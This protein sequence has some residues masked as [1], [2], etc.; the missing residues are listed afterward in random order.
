M[1]QSRYGRGQA[2]E[3]LDLEV[4]ARVGPS[5]NTRVGRLFIL[6]SSSSASVA[7]ASLAV[8]GVKPNASKS[9]PHVSL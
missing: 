8:L 1:S 4:V 2:W 7:E 9:F 6:T 3:V 5:G